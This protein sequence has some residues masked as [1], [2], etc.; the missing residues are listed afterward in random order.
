MAELD[1]GKVVGEQGPAGQPG[2]AGQDG[3]T[4]TITENQ[5]NSEYVYKLDIES[6]T[7]KFTTPNLIGI[8][9]GELVSSFNGRTGTVVPATG[10]YTAEM[11]GAATMEQ[12]NTAIQTAIQSSIMD[13]WEASY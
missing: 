1:L 4:P 10:D 3:I 7:I 11:V 6:G 13:S 2:P 12:V 5:D 8:P 9:E